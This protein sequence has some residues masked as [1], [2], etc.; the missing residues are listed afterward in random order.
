MKNLNVMN[1]HEMRKTNGGYA[2]QCKICGFAS[3][4]Y[5]TTYANALKCVTRKYGYKVYKIVSSIIPR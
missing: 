4:N 2:F 5:W 1:E 3:R